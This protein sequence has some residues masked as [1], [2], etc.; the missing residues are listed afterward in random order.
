[1]RNRGRCTAGNGTLSQVFEN[2][3]LRPAPVTLEPRVLSFDIETDAKGERLLAISLFA[4]GIDEVLIVDGSGRAMP[5]F[6]VCC[7][8]E[9]AA[10]AQFA[11]R[12][13]SF[14]PDSK[15]QPNQVG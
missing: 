4:P 9:A 15:D 7:P 6:A 3:A 12:V 2:P 14:D 5:K 8:N 10:L 11:E 1:M 13:S